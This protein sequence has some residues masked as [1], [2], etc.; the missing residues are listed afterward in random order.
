M[1]GMNDDFFAGLLGGDRNLGHQVV[2]YVPEQQWCFYDCQ[3]DYFVPTTEEKLM[4]LLSQYLIHCC[5]EMPRFT[6]IGGLFLRFRSEDRLKHIVKKAKAMLAA[7]KTF[8]ESRKRRCGERILDPAL[9]PVHQG[10]AD[11]R[12]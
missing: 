6:D 2:F 4:I 12:A 5:Q 8:F 3:F 1:V 9:E 10:G 7:D 11:G